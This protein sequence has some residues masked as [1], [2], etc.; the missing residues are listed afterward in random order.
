MLIAYDTVY[1]LKPEGRFGEKT[2]LAA[3]NSGMQAGICVTLETHDFQVTYE[4]GK[5]RVYL[6]RHL[7]TEQARELANALLKAA[8]T[9][10]ELAKQFTVVQTPNNQ[11]TY[12]SIQQDVVGSGG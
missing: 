10:D 3:C 1:E 5:A 6:S 2:R 11:V 4:D 12:V 8:D 9:N 7:T